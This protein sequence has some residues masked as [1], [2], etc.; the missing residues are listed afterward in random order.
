MTQPT[1]D[2]TA[3]LSS[4]W[5]AYVMIVLAIFPFGNL[6]DTAIDIDTASQKH[7]TSVSL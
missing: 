7:R 1:Y 5:K 3:H 2:G 4:T 6:G